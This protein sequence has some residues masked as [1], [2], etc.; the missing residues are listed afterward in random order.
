V[1]KSFAGQDGIIF[2]ICIYQG[3]V[4]KLYSFLSA[5]DEVLIRPN[6]KFLVMKALYKG[7]DGFYYVELEEQQKILMF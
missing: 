3:K 4:I 6:S 5:E 1:A 7:S 2:K